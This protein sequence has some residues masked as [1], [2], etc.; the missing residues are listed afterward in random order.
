ML[1]IPSVTLSYKYIR[2]YRSLSL[3]R[4]YEDKK[5]LILR[6]LLSQIYIIY[7]IK[8][9]LIQFIIIIIKFLKK[10]NKTYK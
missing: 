10:T 9:I 5:D 3:Y 7:L 2:I 1:N 8:I 4:F 6:V